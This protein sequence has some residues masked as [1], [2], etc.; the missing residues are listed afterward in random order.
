MTDLEQINL[1]REM[2]RIRRFELRALNRFQRG[3]MG[4]WLQL[5]VGQES[6]PV[7]IRSVMGANDHTLC[8][9]RGLGYALASGVSMKAL[10]AELYGK[11]TGVSKGKGGATTVY[12][13]ETRFWG[14]YPI[15]AAQTPLG[16]GLAFA[17]KHRD[18]KGA[19]FCSLGEGSVNQG[20]FH[21]A[22]NLAG[23]FDLP[24]V[25]VVEN[26]HHGFWRT[27]RESSAFK[28]HLARR[29]E[30][31]DIEWSLADAG[32]VWSLRDELMNAQ[33]RARQQ[34]RPTVIEVATYRFYGASVADAS[35]KIYRTPQEI[36][37]H[38]EF[39]DP[40]KQWRRHLIESGIAPAAE[41]DLI[42]WE[43]KIEAH[44]ASEFAESSRPP[45][46]NEL[47][48]DVYWEVDHE[49]EASRQGRHFF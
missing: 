21:E 45:R 37:F 5:T 39:Y 16:A 48:E 9:F 19:V 29:S 22:L 40:I 26:N 17:L 49:T 6:I 32:D 34:S 14:S 4:G 42:V 25:Y 1:F 2:I 30:A 12:S 18:E 35:H 33:E 31:Y 47:T 11:A 27:E 7:A 41:L 38:K 24:V 13:P 43:A 44:E 20:V 36:D 46:V 3:E 10:M 8:G 23:L 15:A 28:D